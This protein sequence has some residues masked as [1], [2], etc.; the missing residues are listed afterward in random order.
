MCSV[1]DSHANKVDVVSLMALF[2][3]NQMLDGLMRCVESGG[4][5]IS[6]G[7]VSVIRKRISLGI[8]PKK[9]I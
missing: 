7:E 5:P 2:F 4:Y 8:D 9:V 1:V 3:V 6:R